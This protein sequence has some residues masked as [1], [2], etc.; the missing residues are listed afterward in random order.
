[1]KKKGASYKEKIFNA[2]VI[3]IKKFGNDVFTLKIRPKNKFRFKAGQFI[4]FHAR[5]DEKPFSIASSP[6]ERDL[7]FLI[8]KNKEG[9]ITP[10]LYSLKKGDAVRFSGPYGSFK[11]RENKK[12]M[13]FI[14]GGIGV[15]PFRSMILDT[16]K[17][18]P[19]KKIILLYG[20]NQ[21]YFFEET[22]RELEKKHKNFKLYLCCLYPPKGW[23]GFRGLVTENFPKIISSSRNKIVYICGPEPMIEAS[24]KKLIEKWGFSSEQLVIEGWEEAKKHI[25]KRTKTQK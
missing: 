17:K 12:E 8:K 18:H 14:A 5:K 24:K 25:S 9:K 22:W 15:A 2:Q 13:L 6:S 3:N 7:E 11:V 1:M 20:F 16:L 21:D 10:Y 4:L 19:T 23:R